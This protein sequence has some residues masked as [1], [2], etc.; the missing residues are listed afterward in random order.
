MVQKNGTHHQL[1]KLIDDLYAYWTDVSCPSNNGRQQWE[2]VWCTYGTCSGFNQTY[3]FQRALALRAQVDLLSI[4]ENNGIVPSSTES[5]KLEDIQNALNATL[6]DSTVVECNQKWLLGDYQLYKIQI[7]VSNDTNS[8]ISCPVQKSSNCGSEV[9]FLPFEP[10]DLP[11]GSAD[12]LA[13]LMIK[14]PAAID[15]DM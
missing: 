9:K 7:C 2:D 12:N 13:D 15:M 11:I 1:R 4:L 10:A 3:Y 14:M 8:I 5:Y 6:G